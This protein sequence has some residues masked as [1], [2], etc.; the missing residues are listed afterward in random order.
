MSTKPKNFLYLFF[1]IDTISYEN[2][3]EIVWIAT[4]GKS[5]KII[6]ERLSAYQTTNASIEFKYIREVP[7]NKNLHAQEQALKKKLRKKYN[8]H[9]HSPEQ[10]VIGDDKQ[11]DIFKSEIG[12]Y[13][14]PIEQNKNSKLIYDYNN[15]NNKSVDIR[16]NRPKCKLIPREPAAITT[17]AGLD[18]GYRTY[19]LLFEVTPGGKI[20]GY[21]KEKKITVSDI[22]HKIIMGF[23][24]YYNITPKLS[25]TNIEQKFGT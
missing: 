22:G 8:Q 20:K 2:K 6:T 25:T 17:K 3:K 1:T 24:K 18:E 10:F 5:E 21:S 11:L 23:K 19:K 12:R 15:L 7:L 13:M 9:R 16:N 14:T 4:M